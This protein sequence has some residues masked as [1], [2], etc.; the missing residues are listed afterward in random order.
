MHRE[1]LTL[2]RLCI[3]VND[4][5]AAAENYGNLGFTL[6]AEGRHMVGSRN[7]CIMLRDGQYIELL[8]PRTSEHNPV[9][10]RYQDHL[11]RY[12]EGLAVMALGCQDAASLAESWRD[13]GLSPSPLRHFS[14]AVPLPTGVTE[15]RFQIVQLPSLILP[16]MPALTVIACQQMTPELVWLPG[17]T[18]HTNGVSSISAIEFQSQEPGLDSEILC[19]LAAADAIPTPPGTSTEAKDIQLGGVRISFTKRDGKKD[20]GKPLTRIAMRAGQSPPHG[21]IR[22]GIELAFS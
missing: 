17:S 19:K 22:H 8:D 9:S 16:G 14:R 13:A 5:D 1:S 10:D 6:T 12:G 2:D 7:R 15:A 20:E 4:L 21:T 18:Q 11:S 3:V